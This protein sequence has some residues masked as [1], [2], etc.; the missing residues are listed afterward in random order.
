MT[1]LVYGRLR[2][3]REREKARF[4][5]ASVSVSSRLRLQDGAGSPLLRVIQPSQTKVCQLYLTP[6]KEDK[7]KECQ[8][9]VCGRLQV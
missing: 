8:E 5:S 2:G 3:G 1:L 6:D 9:S 7:A 4:V